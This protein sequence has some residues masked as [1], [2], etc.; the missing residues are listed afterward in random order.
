MIF[1]GKD[2][3]GLYVDLVVKKV[4]VIELIKVVFDWIKVIDD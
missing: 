4:S 3:L 1:Y 2:I